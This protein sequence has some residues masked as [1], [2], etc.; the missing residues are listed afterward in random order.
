MKIIEKE[1]REE[2]DGLVAGLYTTETLTEAFTQVR[3]LEDYLDSIEKL[4]PK[5]AEQYNNDAK[6]FRE[7]LNQMINTSKVNNNGRILLPPKNQD[8]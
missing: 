2:L 7:Y 8:K 5:I 4:Y 3:K 1:L 6:E